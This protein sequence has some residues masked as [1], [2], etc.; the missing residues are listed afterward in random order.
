MA[1]KAVRKRHDAASVPPIKD[2]DPPDESQEG[3][4]VLHYQGENHFLFIYQE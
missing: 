2:P 4:Y 3:K 1:A